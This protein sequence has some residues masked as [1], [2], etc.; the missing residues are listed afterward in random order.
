MSAWK[1][2]E[3][4]ARFLLDRFAEE[5]GLKSVEGKQEVE[6]LRSG[7]TW[8]ID[9]KGIRE[10]NSGFVIIECR[11]H[12]TSPQKQEHL[13]ALAYRIMDTGASGGI[14]VTP[15]GLQKGARKVASAENIIEV[16]LAEDSKP[17]QF[18]L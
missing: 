10:M 18:M 6:G 7:T 17:Y 8:E 3:D 13:A 1:S 9:A 16:R 14:I 12:T 15:L 4:V 11:R 2:Y 5:F